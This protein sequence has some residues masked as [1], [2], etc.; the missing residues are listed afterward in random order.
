MRTNGSVHKAFVC[1]LRLPLVILCTREITA[2]SIRIVLSGELGD[3]LFQYAF[4]RAL[5]SSTG[6]ELNCVHEESVGAT[7]SPNVHTWPDFKNAPWYIPGHVVNDD[8]DIFE[9][10]RDGWSGQTIDIGLL[11]QRSPRRGIQLRGYFQ[12]YEYYESVQGQV[13]EWLTPVSPNVLSLGPDD[14]AVFARRDA[15]A[16]RLHWIIPT[17]YYTEIL[18]SLSPIG[19]VYVFG[20]RF[21]VTLRHALEPYEPVYMTGAAWQQLQAM[22]QFPRVII[23]NSTVAWWAAFLGIAEEVYGSTSKYGDFYAFAGF[24]EV[25]LR[26]PEPRYRGVAIS[27]AGW[28]ERTIR[29]KDA[30]AHV[31]AVDGCSVIALT[32]GRTV[33]LRNPALNSSDVLWL[34]RQREPLGESLVRE[35]LGAKT[36]HLLRS[37]FQFGILEVVEEHFTTSDGVLNDDS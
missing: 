27:R 13:R 1:G 17:S 29:S 10:G 34:I 26:L 21:D 22:S 20:D 18:S 19:R 35:R 30:A 24:R 11:C 6:L 12:R 14:V 28:F 25:D 3:Q 16:D 5:Q 37:L 33:V 2:V 36:D 9:I 31:F 7:E 15:L 8:V 4:G 32:E 23:G